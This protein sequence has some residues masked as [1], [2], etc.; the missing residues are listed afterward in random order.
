MR[1]FK[2]GLR[3]E[4]FYRSSKAYSERFQRQTWSSMIRTTRILKHVVEVIIAF[5]RKWMDGWKKSPEV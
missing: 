1:V 3:L 5:G 2:F 4:Q